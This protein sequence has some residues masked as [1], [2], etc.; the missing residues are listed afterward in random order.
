M[1]TVKCIDPRTITRRIWIWIVI[2]TLIVWLWPIEY[3]ITRFA[4]TTGLATSWAGALFLWWNRKRLRVALISCGILPI[5]IMCLPGRAPDPAGLG[6]DYAK[7]L[8]VYRGVRYVWGGE[9]L[10]GIDCSGL[11]RKG[12][13]WG[14]LFHGLR[15]VN[16]RPIRDAVIL[17]WHDASAMALRDGYR[18]WTEELFRCERIEDA[19]HER[20]KPGDLAVTVDGVHVL[21][22]LGD[23]TW[24][25]ADP[26]VR[27]VI[28]VRLPSYN[29]WLN[30]PVIFVRWKWLGAPIEPSDEDTLA[31]E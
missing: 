9:G 7:G 26:D 30:R 24:I 4:L 22:Y 21:A 17:W 3:R 31:S 1:R 10:L 25:Q 16:G 15:T 27:K 19:D 14:Q 6:A 5:V 8:Q 18:D 28:E 20:L 2:L 12:L 29:S 11:V 13:V 23:H